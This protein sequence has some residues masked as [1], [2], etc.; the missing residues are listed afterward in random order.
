MCVA[1][2]GYIFVHAGLE[3]ANESYMNISLAE[4]L[5]LVRQR[6]VITPRL[7]PL[8]GRELVLDTPL[9]LVEQGV[10]VVSGHHGFVHF[11]PYRV[12]VDSS[13][14][15]AHKNLSCVIFPE[16]LLLDHKGRKDFIARVQVFP[17]K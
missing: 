13:G 2:P 4:Q 17:G 16:L 6:D 10:C 12:I 14:G 5:Q 1:C 7:E 11:G 8:C 3:I 15:L 9:E